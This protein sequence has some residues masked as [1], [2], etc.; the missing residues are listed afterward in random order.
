MRRPV[1]DADPRCDPVVAWRTE[2]LRAAGLSPELARRIAC[3]RGYDV[4]AVLELVDRGC[5]PE[6]AARIMA[7]IEP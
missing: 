2:R 3:D 5:S 1:T 6:L 4:H 7:P